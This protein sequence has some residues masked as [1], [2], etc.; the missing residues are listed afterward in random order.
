MGVVMEDEAVTATSASTGVE[1]NEISEPGAAELAVAEGEATTTGGIPRSRSIRVTRVA[2][3]LLRLLAGSQSLFT[4]PA[5]RELSD[6]VTAQLIKALQSDTRVSE[7]ITA[8][9]SVEFDNART[10]PFFDIGP[11]E[12]G[13]ALGVEA[14]EALR[15]NSSVEFRVRIPAKNQPRYRSMDDV[16]TDEYLVSWDGTVLY[17]QWDQDH[18]GSTG[19]GGHVVLTIIEEITRSAGF[20]AVVMACS[21][22]CHHRFIH[23]DFV[24]FDTDDVPDHYHKIGK[25]PTGSGFV[26]PIP[27]GTD[28]VDD[29]RRMRSH[30]SVLVETFAATKTIADAILYW[31]WRARTD[32]G[33]TIAIAY[34]RA[35]KRPWYRP[36]GWLVD[37]WG[38]RG[39]SRHTKKLLSGQ[40]LCLASIDSQMTNWREGDRRFAKR[41]E[42]KRLKELATLFDTSAD[43]VRSL[44]TTTV[45]ASLDDVASRAEGRSLRFATLAGAAC[46]LVGAIFGAAAAAL[47]T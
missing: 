9:A 27:V 2:V 4:F 23:G 11:D 3:C 47:L 24:Q 5:A 25:S 37:S 6:R 28:A 36:I 8:P 34:E 32:A 10:V 13:P 41:L 21:R 19:S 46:A 35:S 30:L 33:T 14:Y 26:A 31:G 44:D 18:P 38:L 43:Q 20:E 45:R 40:W 16:P 12:D 39:S 22:G 29:L 7:V 42:T 15:L 1:R 17:V